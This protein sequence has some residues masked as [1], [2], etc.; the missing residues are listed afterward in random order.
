FRPP[1]SPVVDAPR[2]TGAR[3]HHDTVESQMDSFLDL[4][5]ASVSFKRY[6]T[7]TLPLERARAM[8]RVISKVGRL[9]AR[10]MRQEPSIE[11]SDDQRS[12]VLGCF[13]HCFQRLQ[14]PR[15]TIPHHVIRHNARAP[16]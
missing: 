9:L 13:H 7:D 2:P 16:E 1:A 11:S 14:I 15:L 5:E 6:A 8:P 12:H 10:G 3:P 4:A